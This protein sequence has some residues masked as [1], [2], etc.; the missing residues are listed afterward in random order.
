MEEE[1]AAMLEERR[2]M[3]AEQEELRQ[4]NDKLSK[5]KNVIGI[6]LANSNEQLQYLKRK[7]SKNMD[8]EKENEQPA[9]GD[10]N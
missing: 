9:D 3:L 8:K 10:A 5:E 1:K 4:L 7:L 6:R 2:R